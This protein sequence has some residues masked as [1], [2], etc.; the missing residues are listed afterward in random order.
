MIA[1]GDGKTG[2]ILQPVA[3]YVVCEEPEASWMWLNRDYASAF[4]QASSCREGEEPNMGTHVNEG[5]VVESINDRADTWIV[6]WI[7]EQKVRPA[8][9]ALIEEAFALTRVSLNKTGG[10]G[11]EQAEMARQIARTTIKAIAILS[12]HRFP[13]PIA[14]NNR[15]TIEGDSRA[16]LTHRARAVS[17][18]KLNQS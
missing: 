18:R 7:T 5:P 15:D 6:S 8:P 14:A 17:H 4:G 12:R 13:L 16:A 2:H 1:Y 11:D 10:V 3:P 9:R